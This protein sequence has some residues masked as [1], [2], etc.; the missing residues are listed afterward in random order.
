MPHKQHRE[1]ASWTKR[2]I[3][4]VAGGIVVVTTSVLMVT[5]SLTDSSD[6]N[7][8]I[9][10]ECTAR[11][12]ESLFLTAQSTLKMC[13]RKDGVIVL[14]DVRRQQSRGRQ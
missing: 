9:E 10:A 13:V 7:A 5:L 2:Q 14:P 11:D 3:L 8:Q 6:T 12:M 1:L 4:S